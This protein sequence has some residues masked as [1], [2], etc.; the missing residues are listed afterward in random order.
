[1]KSTKRTIKEQEILDL[2]KEIGLIH[3]KI[4][5]L[6]EKSNNLSNRI[7]LAKK[8]LNLIEENENGA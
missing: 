6:E 3:K 1:M 2:E 4:D 7:I 5:A 8:Q